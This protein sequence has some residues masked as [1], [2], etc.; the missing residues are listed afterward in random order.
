MSS[1]RKYIFTGL[2]YSGYFVNGL[3]EIVPV[4][5]LDIAE[6]TH[7]TAADVSF[8]ISAKFIG[9]LCGSLFFGWALDRI[10]RQIALS[11]AIAV[12]TA[13]LS[14][15]PLTKSLSLYYVAYWINGFLAVAVDISSFTWIIEMWDPNANPYMQGLFLA[16]ACGS[17]LSAVIAEPFLSRIVAG[18]YLMNGTASTFIET[19]IWIPYTM[20][21]GVAFL[22]SFL[23][24]LM[25]FTNK[26]TITTKRC[27]DDDDSM[28]GSRS[29]DLV[30][31]DEGQQDVRPAAGSFQIMTACL[32]LAFQSS[33]QTTVSSF[34]PTFVVFCDLHLTKS[35]AAFLSSFGLAVAVLTMMLSIG[36]AFR[37]SVRKMLATELLVTSVGLVML[38]VADK[39]SMTMLYVSVA[40]LQ[41]GLTTIFPSMYSFLSE[42]MHVT[43]RIFG[44][45]TMSKSISRIINP[46]ITGSFIETR[47]IVF[48][49]L[50]LVSVSLSFLMF[51]VFVVTSYRGHNRNPTTAQGH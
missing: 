49:Y 5:L 47:P 26:C 3:Q 37:V 45:I 39:I 25:F 42:E 9:Y 24:I 19:R 7:S 35:E 50:C 20:I 27:N 16:A 11:F 2:I 33:L 38:T 1:M 30:K 4:T 18:G 15:I 43:N 31:C 13:A 36:V 8:G 22:S 14:T 12:Y 40:V 32:M 10:N 44:W 48:N 17:A 34:L 29:N 41:I 46:L 28:S 6:L 21:S 51:F 23:M